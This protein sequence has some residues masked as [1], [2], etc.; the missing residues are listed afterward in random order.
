M[1]KITKVKFLKKFLSIFDFGDFFHDYCAMQIT[2]KL[3]SLCQIY[4]VLNSQKRLSLFLIEE[5]FLYMHMK[6]GVFSAVFHIYECNSAISNPITL[7][8]GSVE[9]EKVPAFI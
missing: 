1:K 3:Q 5:P 2:S 7:V 9:F 6:N 8:S 4:A